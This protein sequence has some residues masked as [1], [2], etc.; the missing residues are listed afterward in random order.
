M[1]RYQVGLRA[2]FNSNNIRV[3]RSVFNKYIMGDTTT[4]TKN[5]SKIQIYEGIINLKSY[6]DTP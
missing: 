1:S 3:E 4:V 5:K 6:K 2:I